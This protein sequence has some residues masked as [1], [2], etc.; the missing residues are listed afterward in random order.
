MISGSDYDPDFEDGPGN[1]PPRPKKRP[2]GVRTFPRKRLKKKIEQRWWEIRP[3]HVSRDIRFNDKK[4]GLG[5]FSTR[6]SFRTIHFNGVHQLKTTMTSQQ[7]DY[8]IE[9]GFDEDYV[10]TPTDKDITNNMLSHSWRINHSIKNPTH[11]L[12]YDP[13]M[14]PQHPHGHSCLTP[15]RWLDSGDEITFDYNNK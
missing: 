5:V 9:S 7:R 10:F 12:H 15:L 11:E 2:R 13:V 4:I 1:E 6:R 8:G 3:S 14:C